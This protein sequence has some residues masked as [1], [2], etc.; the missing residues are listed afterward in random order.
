MLPRSRRA[1]PRLTA[2]F[3]VALLALSGVA[4]CAAVPPP[5]THTA[6]PPPPPSAEE[7]REQAAASWVAQAS[8]REL[9]GSVIMATAPTTD[10]AEL[11]TL[12]EDTGLGGFIVMGANVPGS[13]D[14]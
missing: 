13:P 8:T 11:R 14:E 1:L 10:A 7:L 2:L 4:G 5:P 3:G 6:E 9:A 12:M